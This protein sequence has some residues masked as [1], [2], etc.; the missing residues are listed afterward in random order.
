MNYK[1]LVA[2]SGNVTGLNVI[3]A[4][5]KHE[6]VYIVGCDFDEENPSRLFCKNYK[7]PRCAEPGYP[8]AMSSI[9]E[10]EHITHIIASNDHDVRALSLMA[11]SDNNFPKFN[12]LSCF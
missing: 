12:C 7:V 5:A 1:V 4:L 3:R 8:D 9:I 11:A 6:D 10:S 2:G